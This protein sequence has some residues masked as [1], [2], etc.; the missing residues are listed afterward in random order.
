MVKLPNEEL[1][2]IPIEPIKDC[3]GITGELIGWVHEQTFSIGPDSDVK[4]HEI[5]PA[6]VES[7]LANNGKC[8]VEVDYRNELSIPKTGYGKLGKVIMHFN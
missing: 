6:D 8:F 1:F 7:I 4:C 3:N 5:T 2:L